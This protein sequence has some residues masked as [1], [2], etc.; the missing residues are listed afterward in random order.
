[1]KRKMSL[2]LS[3]EEY[4]LIS[5]P[6]TTQRRTGIPFEVSRQ[7]YPSVTLA[8]CQNMQSTVENLVHYYGQGDDDDLGAIA[9]NLTRYL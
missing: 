8:H 3:R 5:I 6:V 4:V 9:V 2:T 1:M 7:V